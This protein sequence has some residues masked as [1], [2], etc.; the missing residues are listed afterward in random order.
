MVGQFQ[1]QG[2]NIIFWDGADLIDVLEGRVDLR[3]AM[4][5]KIEKAAQEGRTFVPLREFSK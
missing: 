5:F 3:D 2:C 1:G 4:K